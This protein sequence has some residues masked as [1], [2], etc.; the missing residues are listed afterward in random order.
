MPLFSPIPTSI[1]KRNNA[2]F[3]VFQ[4]TQ[5]IIFKYH[6]KHKWGKESSNVFQKRENKECIRACAVVMENACNVVT[7]ITERYPL[8]T[9]LP[10]SPK[11]PL[12][13]EKLWEKT[14]AKGEY[15][16]VEGKNNTSC[17]RNEACCYKTVERKACVYL[18]IVKQYM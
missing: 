1:K 15:A 7:F 12:I 5:Q 11:L 16:V 18:D 9:E 8:T 13:G 17:N 4:C 3:G 10:H 2:V 14:L 6:T